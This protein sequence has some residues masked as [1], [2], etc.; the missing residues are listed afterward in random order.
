MENLFKYDFT[1][2]TGC[3]INTRGPLGELITVNDKDTVRIILNSSSPVEKK[4]ALKKSKHVYVQS[5]EF[6][7]M[8]RTINGMIVGETYKLE[9]IHPE[10]TSVPEPVAEPS[11]PE[12]PSIENDKYIKLDDNFNAVMYV[13]EV[14]KVPVL[15][16]GIESYSGLKIESSDVAVIKVSGNKLTAI[17]PGDVR[18]TVKL[19]GCETY[20]LVEVKAKESKPE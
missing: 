9:I 11:E 12:A 2:N 3:S 13:G 14:Q 15:K 1:N 5:K 8:M 20:A 6:I 7:Q 10:V 16:F 18:I 19:A 4:V 17:N